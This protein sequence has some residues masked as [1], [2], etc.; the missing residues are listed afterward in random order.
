[1]ARFRQFTLPPFGHVLPGVTALYTLV[2]MPIAL[3]RHVWDE[4]LRNEIAQCSS[5]RIR[6]GWV[7][8]GGM[9]P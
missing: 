5:G 3:L 1:M 9:L 4:S 7:F 6:A 8:V 2:S